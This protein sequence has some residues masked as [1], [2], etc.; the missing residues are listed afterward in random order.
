[1]E[2]QPFEVR[3]AK[4]FREI[5]AAMAHPRIDAIAATSDTLFRANAAELADLATKQRLPFIG[6]KEFAAAGSL[7]GYGVDTPGLYRRAP[8]FVDRIL[9]GAK[10]DDLPIE[11]AT[12]L[13]LVINLKTAKGLRGNNLDIWPLDWDAMLGADRAVW[14][15]TQ[16]IRNDAARPSPASQTF[17]LFASR[18]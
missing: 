10:P 16:A 1:L 8:Y 9:K 4:E 14:R 12:R 5:H 18:P 2:L 13:E 11:R 6:P 7:I 17:K 15:A 3:N